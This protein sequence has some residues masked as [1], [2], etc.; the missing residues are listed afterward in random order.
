M[1]WS[2]KSAPALTPKR[3]KPFPAWLRPGWRLPARRKVRENLQEAA[4]EVNRVLKVDPQ[5]PDALAFKKKNDALHCFH[6]R[7]NAR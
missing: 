2:S 5:N 4:T 1:R 7:Q 3:R 6:A